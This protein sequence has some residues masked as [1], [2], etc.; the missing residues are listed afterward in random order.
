MIFEKGDEIKYIYSDDKFIVLDV[1]E[2]N[3]CLYVL[4]K[5]LGIKT[6]RTID[7]FDEEMYVATGVKYKIEI[8]PIVSPVHDNREPVAD[9][10]KKEIANVSYELKRIVNELHALNRKK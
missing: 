1:D 2:V 3:N 4:N 10:L 5:D 8:T 6:I 7:K 9:I